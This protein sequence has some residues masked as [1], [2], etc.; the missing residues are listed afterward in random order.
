M[1]WGSSYYLP[2]VLAGPI[3]SDTGWSLSWVVGGL[4][5]GLAAAGIVSP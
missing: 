1:A 4:S 5:V 3:S 2:A